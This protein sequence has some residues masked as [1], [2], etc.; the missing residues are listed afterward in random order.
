MLQNALSQ[1]QLAKPCNV[2]TYIFV[3]HVSAAHYV[4]AAGLSTH[5]A[6]SVTTAPP[7]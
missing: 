6:I 5:S 7:R 3:Q 2:I 4:K 1:I